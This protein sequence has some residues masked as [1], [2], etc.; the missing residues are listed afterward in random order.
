M[1]RTFHLYRLAIALVLSVVIVLSV[2]QPILAK[3]THRTQNSPSQ[4]QAEEAISRYYM[5]GGPFRGKNTILRF[6]SLTYLSGY[7]VSE[8]SYSNPEEQKK[9]DGSTEFWRFEVCAQYWFTSVEF[10]VT[11]Q[12]AR[13]TFT[14]EGNNTTGI[15]NGIGMSL[16]SC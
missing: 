16:E 12:T 14:L 15:W 1:S 13:H 6:D 2:T 10:P 4:A 3:T 8:P 5:H 9:V 11:E 7:S